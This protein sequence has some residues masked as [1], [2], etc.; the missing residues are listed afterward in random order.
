MNPRFFEGIIE[1]HTVFVVSWVNPDASH[2]EVGME[3]YVE[4]GYLAAIRVAKEI[5]GVKQVN[6][7]GYCIAGTT[8]ALTLSLLKKRGDTSIKSATFFTA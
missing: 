8:L 5:C 4:D 7:V 3:D 6:A 2:A 1:G